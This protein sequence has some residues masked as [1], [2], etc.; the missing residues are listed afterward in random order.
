MRSESGGYGFGCV[1]SK[2]GDGEQ[3]WH[4][5]GDSARGGDEH[6]R[7]VIVFFAPTAVTRDQG[8]L[9]IIRSSNR[10]SSDPGQKQGELPPA[11]EASY[12][13]WMNVYAM[14]GPI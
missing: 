13:V 11:L 1:V 8:P 3:N 9:E 2:P 4:Q 12:K 7:T 6:A 5:D 10:V 14:A